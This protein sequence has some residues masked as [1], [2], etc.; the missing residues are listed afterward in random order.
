MRRILAI[1]FIAFGLVHCG[2]GGGGGGPGDARSDL[3]ATTGDVT[4]SLDVPG[5]MD[6]RLDGSVPPSDA[7]GDAR[8]DAPSD[9]PRADAGPSSSR[10]T[11]R[12]IGYM[13]AP[14]GF[15]EYVPPGYGDGVPRPLLLFWHGVDEDGDGSAADLPRVL[16][17]G[18]PSLISRNLWDATRPFIVLSPQ[19][20]SGC[21]SADTVRNFLRWAFAHYPIDRARVYLTGMSCGAIGS[22]N[23]INAY[24]NDNEITAAV[25]VCGNGRAPWNTHHCDLGRI[26]IWAFHGGSDEVVTLDDQM[27]VMTGFPT[28]NRP[29]RNRAESE[30]TYNEWLDAGAPTTGGLIGCAPATRRDARFTVYPGVGHNAWARTYDL[31]AGHDVYA[32][33]LSMS[34]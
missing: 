20:A 23:Y 5:G 21:P 24:L 25:L 7:R 28:D 15:Y 27:F 17:N 14:S 8:S 3:D 29:D 26:G 6:A 30:R 19:N 31:S 10:Q 33:L 13:G 11:M 1:A 4:A 16:R 22:W 9:A 34:R 18:P 12:V 32:W 2:D